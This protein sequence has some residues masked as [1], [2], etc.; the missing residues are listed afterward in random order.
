MAY[1][2]ILNQSRLKL[3]QMSPRG[4]PTSDTRYMILA[5]ILRLLTQLTMRLSIWRTW[6]ER[7]KS[8]AMRML[9]AEDE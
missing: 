8:E 4:G 7:I 3:Q 1:V 5:R 2:L 6:N 9:E